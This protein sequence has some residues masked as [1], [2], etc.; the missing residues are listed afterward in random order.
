MTDLLS[1]ITTILYEGGLLMKIIEGLYYSKE[2]EWIKVNDGDKA[3]VGITDFTK[4]ALGDIVFIE[5]PEVAAEF[6]SG[7]EFGVVKSVKAASD[8]YIPISGQIIEVNE[9]LVNNPGA[10]NDD[11]YKN[12]LA[13]VKMSDKSQISELLNAEDYENFCS[14]EGELNSFS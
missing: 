3:Y 10:I 6:S 7:D 14:K 1:T 8:I 13:I 5:L 2:H 12:W 11:A 9:A 4:Q